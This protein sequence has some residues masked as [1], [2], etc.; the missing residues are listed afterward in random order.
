MAVFRVEKNSN[1][2]TMC[3]YHLR[4]RS[5]TL[6]AKG[7]LSML[8]SLPEKWHYS[9]RGL[10]AISLEG[11]DG[12]VAALKELEGHGYLERRQRRMANG[13]MGETEYTIYEGP[14]EVP[15]EL[16]KKLPEEQPGIDLPYTEKPYM[17]KPY[18]AEPETGAPYTVPPLQIKKEGSKKETEKK[19][20]MKKESNKG[21]TEKESSKRGPTKKEP[22][23]KGLSMKDSPK[24]PRKPSKKDPKKDPVKAPMKAP[25]VK[26]ILDVDE[27]SSG[28][29]AEAGKEQKIPLL[30]KR[31]GL[32][33]NVFLTDEDLERLR[34]EF[35]SDYLERIERLSEYTAS[36]GKS[37]KNHLATIRSW[38]RKETKSTAG[39][40]H[41]KYRFDEGES[42]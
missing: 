42:L 28:T 24:A 29:E 8:L 9:V 22:L 36:T 6:K 15:K 37:Y 35:P 2:T 33:Q 11:T 41:D 31:Y 20:S 34:E 4:D 18:A 17:E 13:R 23:N 10:A 26:A 21:M 27:P 19:D 38:A 32:Y 40:G 1:Y 39:Y 16:P 7:L 12:I 3:N 5:I 14:K 30:K 25:L